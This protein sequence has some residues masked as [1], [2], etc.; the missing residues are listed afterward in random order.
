MELLPAIKEFIDYLSKNQTG[1][2]VDNYDNKTIDETLKIPYT[3]Y[4]FISKYIDYICINNK[5]DSFEQLNKLVCFLSSINYEV[6]DS[7]VIFLIRNNVNF[8]NILNDVTSNVN[9]LNEFDSSIAITI[10]DIYSEYK[11]KE[12]FGEQQDK[13]ADYMND[14]MREYLNSIGKIPLLSAEEE[15]QLA[16]LA[17]NGDKDAKDRLIQSNLRF[18]V[19]VARRYYCNGLD[20]LDLIQEGNI[21]LIDAVNRFD[22]HK[23]FRFTTYAYWWIKQKILRAIVEK[24]RNI[25]LPLA[26]YFKIENIKTIT[27]ALRTKLNREPTIEEISESSNIPVPELLKLHPLQ[28]DTVSMESI[29][30]DSDSEEGKK[31]EDYLSDKDYSVE[32]IVIRNELDKRIYEVLKNCGLT[33]KQINILMLRSG[34]DGEVRT[35]EYIAKKYGVSRERIRQAESKALNKIRHSKNIGII[36]EYSDDSDYYLKKNFEIIRKAAIKEFYEYFSEYSVEEINDAIDKLDNSDKEYLNFLYDDNTKYAV[37]INFVRLR[38]I[39]Y[40]VKHILNPSWIIPKSTGRKRIEVKKKDVPKKEPIIQKENN[41]PIIEEENNQIDDNSNA[42]IEP[43]DKVSIH[44]KMLEVSRS[45]IFN[46]LKTIFSNEQALILILSLGYIDYRHFT[47]S[48]IAEIMG[49]DET[50]VQNILAE[51]LTTYKNKI[52]KLID[53]VVIDAITKKSKES[54]ENGGKKYVKK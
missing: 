52:D 8:L 19:A 22:P 10:I 51:T 32:N 50:R 41:K 47:N 28:Y 15:K 12:L 17:Q 13:N 6:S 9:K 45:N 7:L 40:K 46:K 1:D 3:A 24:N 44:L 35:L 36:A 38:T 37:D 53:E 11:E 42:T 54:K 43:L 33:D 16:I 20:M 26:V 4:R 27:S 34:F 21:G 49:I 39:K 25:R 48:E 30:T 29:I 31:L 2:N 18:V 5:L 23:G 14:G